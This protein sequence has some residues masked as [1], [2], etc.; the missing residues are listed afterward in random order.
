MVF[1]A[2]SVLGFVGGLTNPVLIILAGIVLWDNFYSLIDLELSERHAAVIWIMWTHR[3]PSTDCIGN[4]KLPTLIKTE[5]EKYIPLINKKELEDTLTDL[6]RM[7]C[8]KRSR[9]DP[10]EWWLREWVSKS[11]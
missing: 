1:A 5:F 2:E 4:K 9:N 8:I 6:V 7:G 3:N 11:F 10:Q